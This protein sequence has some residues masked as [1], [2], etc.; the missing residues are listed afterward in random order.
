MKSTVP[1]TGNLL[2]VEDDEGLRCQY[3]WTFPDIKLHLAGSRNEAIAVLRRQPVAAAIVDLGLPPAPDDTTEGFATV[4][5][6]RELSPVTKVIVATGQEDHAHALKAIELGAFDFYQK[7]VPLDVFRYIV[8]RALQLFEL[9]TEYR[10][11]SETRM[12]SPIDGIVASSPQMISLLRNLEKIATTDVAV[13]LL[14]ESGTGKELLAQALHQ[15]SR[16]SGKPFA[17]I[18]CAAIPEA[19]LESELFGHEKG[20][21]TGALKQTIGK[22][23]SADGG[24]LFLDEIGDVPQA[25]QVK[26]LRF[27]QNR[28]VER[29]GGRRAI[30]VDVRIV[31]ATNQDLQR[32]IGEGRFREDLFYRINEI[33]IQVPPLRERL[34]DTVLLSTHFLTRFAREFDRPLRGFTASG[35]EAIERHGWRGN[36][37]ELENR[38]KRAVIMATGP[39]VTAGDL[40]LAEPGGTPQSLDLREA[41]LQAEAKVLHLALSQAGANLSQAAKLLGISRPTLYDLL[42]QHGLNT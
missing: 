36:V 34:G 18:N 30:Q 2:I 17:P 27:L 24:T 28:I 12:L 6:I 15:L 21:F 14:G 26:L 39:L 22:I 37:R 23:E 16:R 3:R 32:L 13:L 1:G 38:I 31:C 35:L 41:R 10:R 7:P 25:M 42:R 4:V 29:V 11:L 8:G 20:A 33:P 40:G 9:E 19:L 5:A